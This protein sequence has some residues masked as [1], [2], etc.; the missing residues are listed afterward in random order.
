MPIFH[1]SSI[2]KIFK[3][4]PEFDQLLNNSNALIEREIRI[5][6]GGEG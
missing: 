3:V 2:K 5:V 6:E 1:T 4:Q